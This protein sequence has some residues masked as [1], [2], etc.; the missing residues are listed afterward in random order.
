MSRVQVVRFEVGQRHFA[1][2]VMAVKEIV[3]P[4][5]PQ[6]VPGQPDFVE[7][8]VEM[9]GEYVP[10]IDLRKRFH[11]EAYGRDARILV[12]TCLQR[13]IALLVDSVGEVQWLEDDDMRTPPLDTSG[14]GA[15]AVDSIA[16]VDGTMVLLLR[17]ESLLD[18]EEWSQVLPL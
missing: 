9:R 18:D 14:G 8:L 6:P 7:G 17:G 13:E 15:Q 12:L 10:L 4:C 3:L 2:D 1:L 16:D 5:T 11:V